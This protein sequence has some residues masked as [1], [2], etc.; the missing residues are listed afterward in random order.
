[1]SEFV[2]ISFPNSCLFMSKFG[3]T[4]RRQT[5]LAKFGASVPLSIFTVK[6]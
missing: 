1:M 6:L 2:T 5:N 4:I 3:Q